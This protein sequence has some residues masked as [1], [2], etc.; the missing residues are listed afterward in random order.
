[1]Q[2]FLI[3]NLHFT[4]T[5]IY[6][7]KYQRSTKSGCKDLEIRKSDFEEKLNSFNKQKNVNFQ[8]YNKQ[9]TNNKE[10]GTNIFNNKFPEKYIFKKI[11]I[12]GQKEYD[13]ISYFVS[14]KI[15]LNF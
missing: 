5:R 6:S 14:H 3:F 11:S 12:L 9:K 10:P 1:M 15:C 13:C 7:L 8:I 4:S 2:T